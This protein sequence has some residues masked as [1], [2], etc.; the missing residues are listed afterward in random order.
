MSNKKFW[1]VIL[2]IVLVFGMTVVGC[3]N[4]PA[5][6]NGVGGYTFEFVVH[7]QYN[8]EITKIEFF[9]GANENASI[10]HTET[11]S[12]KYTEM[13]NIYKVSGFTNKQGYDHARLC[14]VRLTI[15]DNGSD[16]TLFD[17]INLPNNSKV[18]VRYQH[19][20]WFDQGFW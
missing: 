12:L 13:S 18:T 19:I 8:F 2:V 17:F 15:N 9:N 14:G 6:E 1:Y 10:L 16:F 4:D 3:D 7:N 20:L 11:L 5:D